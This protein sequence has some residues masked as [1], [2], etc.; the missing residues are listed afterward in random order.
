[1]LVDLRALS[2]EWASAADVSNGEMPDGS[3]D[4]KLLA[5]RV[6]TTVFQSDNNLQSSNL[7]VTLLCLHT[8]SRRSC[9]PN[10]TGTPG[11]LQRVVRGL[12]KE[13]DKGEAT[14]SDDG[15]VREKGY[16]SKRAALSGTASHSQPTGESKKKRRFTLAKQPCGGT[17]AGWRAVRGEK[18]A[19]A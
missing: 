8:A 17:L 18:E 1:M 4:P 15:M 19:L 5:P 11:T 9:I 13:E 10:T 2:K 3:H 6:C 14:P 16:M 12:D 7:A